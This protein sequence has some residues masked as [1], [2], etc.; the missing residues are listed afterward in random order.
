MLP[1]VP[2]AA[3]VP[4]LPV[5]AVVEPV[6]DAEVGSDAMDCNSSSRLCNWLD[7]CWNG[8]AV[9]EADA[10]RGD[11]LDDVV[12]P[13]PLVVDVAV[14]AAALKS[15]VPDD[16]EVVL[17]AELPEAD[18]CSDWIERSNHESCDAPAAP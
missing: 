2:V 5:A 3:V 17:A 15:L 6:L 4:V 9:S 1:V 7:N 8:L 18:F 14:L 11:P 12:V 16:A 10:V 13:V